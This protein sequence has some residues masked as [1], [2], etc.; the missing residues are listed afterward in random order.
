MYLSKFFPNLEQPTGNSRDRKRAINLLFFY[1]FCILLNT[2]QF[3]RKETYTSSTHHLRLYRAEIK[4]KVQNRFE[5][6]ILTIVRLCDIKNT[7]GINKNWPIQSILHIKYILTNNKTF[8]IMANSHYTI[9][10]DIIVQ[11]P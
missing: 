9:L 11:K 8:C 7:T 1:I 10:L 2:K 3:T 6:D 4:I 5:Y